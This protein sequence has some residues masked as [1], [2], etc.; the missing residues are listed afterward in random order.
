MVL[1][2]CLAHPSDADVGPR[3]RWSGRCAG[4]GARASAFL[5]F[6]KER[7]GS[8]FRASSSPIPGQAQFGIVQGGVSPALR[9]ES[10]RGTVGDRFRGVRHRR[11]ERWRA[12]RRHVRHRGAHDALSARGSAALSDGRRHAAGPR[13]SRWRAA[14][15]S[16]TACCPTRN[17]RNGQLFTSEGRHQYQEC[18][19][20]GGRP[21]ARSGV[22]LLHLPDV[23]AGVFAAPFSGRRDQ[24]V[25][26]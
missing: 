25:H 5:R 9:E 4:R 1:D 19:V 20:R 14:S 17:A 13:R 2:E 23:F 8:R 16:S 15:I 6:T 26:P 12:R 22:R 18:A 11:T 21:A 24:R 3:S 7:D 10:A